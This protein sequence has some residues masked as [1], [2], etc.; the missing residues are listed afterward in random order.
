MG[1]LKVPQNFRLGGFGAVAFTPEVRNAFDVLHEK[2]DTHSKSE[3]M[4]RSLIWHANIKGAK[5]DNGDVELA[6]QFLTDNFKGGMI[7]GRHSY[8]FRSAIL[9]L[10]ASF[11]P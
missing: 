8:I 7:F 2:L 6:Y 5:L 9:N 3:V 10:A 11:S 1:N 4:R